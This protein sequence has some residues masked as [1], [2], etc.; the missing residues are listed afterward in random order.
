[1]YMIGKAM[2]G[3]LQD[4]KRHIR[5]DYKLRW[6]KN[7]IVCHIFEGLYKRWEQQDI[8]V[9][10]ANK[11]KEYKAKQGYKAALPTQEEE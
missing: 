11:G 8:L 9:W 5:L 1:M 7:G 2:V 6:R 4:G 3:G 10:V